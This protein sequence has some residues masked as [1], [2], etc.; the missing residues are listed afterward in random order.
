MAK[1]PRSQRSGSIVF[2]VCMYFTKEPR[3][4][5]TIRKDRALS[6]D[7]IA[8]IEAVIVKSDNDKSLKKIYLVYAY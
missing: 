8:L 1:D 7:S 3:K 2:G 6:K 4:R 5:L